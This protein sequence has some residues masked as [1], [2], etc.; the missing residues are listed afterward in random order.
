VKGGAA[1]KER[2]ARASPLDA[3]KQRAVKAFLADA[4]RMRNRGHPEAA[5]EIYGQAI[6]V[7]PA[8]GDALAGRGSCYLDLS[9]YEPAEASFRAAL[10]ADAENGAA[11]MG[12]AE[13]FRY[14]G[15]RTEAVKYYEQYLAAHPHGEEAV[16]ARNAIQALK[17]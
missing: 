17:E 8:N 5:L 15:R 13:T 9:Q 12:L 14:E 4:R 2:T 16:A 1:K 6:E 7:D 10:G 11:L 3:K